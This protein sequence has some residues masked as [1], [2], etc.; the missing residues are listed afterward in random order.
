MRLRAM[1]IAGVGVLAVSG[2]I[3]L[4]LLA[5]ITQLPRPTAAGKT[6]DT[7]S[8]ALPSD[9]DKIAFLQQY[10][11]LPSPIA[12]TEFHIVYHDNAAG[13]LPGPSDWDMQAAIKVTPADLPRWT[14]GMQQVATGEVDLGWGYALLPHEP[15]WTIASQ[16][17]VYTRAGTIVAVFEREGIVF[18]RVFTT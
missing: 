10:L 16:P 3:L 5:G 9:A 4:W 2:L 1:I 12:A 13:G 14:D 17:V 6:T 7:R 15:R 18:K 11:T 8:A